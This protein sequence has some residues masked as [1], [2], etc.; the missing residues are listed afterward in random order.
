MAGAG[1]HTLH[2]QQ[3]RHRLPLGLLPSLPASLPPP[4]LPLPLTWSRH[5]Q[6]CCCGLYYWQPGPRLVAPSQR[7]EVEVAG[8]QRPRQWGKRAGWG[9]ISC[10]GSCTLLGGRGGLA[11]G[12]GGGGDRVSA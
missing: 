1:S 7:G 3:L 2:Q 5:W 4:L 8:R 9:G 10:R 11:T 6:C 12:S